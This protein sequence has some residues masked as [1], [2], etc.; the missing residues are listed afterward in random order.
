VRVTP[1]ISAEQRRLASEAQRLESENQSLR[2]RLAT[3][4]EEARLAQKNIELLRAE[5]AQLKIKSSGA[6]Q[7]TTF[8]LAQVEKIR[9][10][11]SVE[12][13]AAREKHLREIADLRRNH[14]EE[15]RAL[16]AGARGE[17]SS[18]SV[19]PGQKASFGI[20]GRLQELERQVAD[21]TGKNTQYRQKNTELRE[22]NGA[23]EDRLRTLLASKPGASPGETPAP[24]KAA[25]AM[26]APT[27]PATQPSEVTTSNEEPTTGTAAVAAS[28]E[29]PTTSTAAV[30]ASNE[31]PTTSTAESSSTPQVAT[32]APPTERDDL[33]ELKGVG[34]AI[35]RA[36]H[37]AG[38]TQ[39]SQIA[40]WTESDID[41]IAPRVKATAARIKKNRWVETAKQKTTPSS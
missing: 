26:A 15:L 38:I 24:A 40:A 23:L 12:M 9:A 3:Q 31:E 17:V 2:D 39:F 34:P 11:H 20:A 25:R 10:E 29:E 14:L 19:L 35:A 36:L 28:N 22:A 13:R 41:S 30:A 18:N 7:T 4:R 1:T 37:A 6:Q 5:L 33:T 27:P 32:A 8:T 16:K 21:L